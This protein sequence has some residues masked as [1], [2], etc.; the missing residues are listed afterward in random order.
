MLADLQHFFTDVF[1]TTFATNV[2]G[3]TVSPRR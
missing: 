1:S 2:P 3:N